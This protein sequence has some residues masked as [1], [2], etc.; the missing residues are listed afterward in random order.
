MSVSILTDTT[1]DLSR[2]M[3]ARYGIVQVP[4]WVMFG[5][6]R[7]RDGIDIT[8]QE[9]T[10]RLSSSKVNPITE[11]ASADEFAAFFAKEIDAGREVVCPV[12]GATLSK[13][14]ESA[15]EAAKRFGGKVHVVDTETFSG[16]LALHAILAAELAKAGLPAAEIAARL[17]AKLATQRGN[18]VLPDVTF[19]G[20]SGRLNK[21]IVSL[22]QMM[23]LSPILQLHH[24]VVDSATQTNNFD[25][26]RKQLTGIALR[27]LPSTAKM[28][29]MVGAVEAPELAKELEAELRDKLIGGCDASYVYEC[30]P[31]VATNSG[32]RACAIYSMQLD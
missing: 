30:G 25:K 32:P 28:R 10:R 17:R 7:F 22:S 18:M 14:F 15:H 9:F 2:E 26:S 29:F 4:L 23:R 11:P 8:M 12:I 19:L 1:S 13:T 5:E 24:G 27:G 6:E 20:R 31:T 3:A 16:G 21:A